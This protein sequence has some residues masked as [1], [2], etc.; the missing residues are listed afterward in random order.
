MFTILLRMLA[1][2]RRTTRTR[3]LPEDGLWRFVVRRA[4]KQISRSAEGET[5][6]RDI[7]GS[8]I[9]LCLNEQR[10]HRAQRCGEGASSRG[11]DC[12][13]HGAESLSVS[14]ANLCVARFGRIQEPIS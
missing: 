13:P 9:C 2:T 1:E 12:E 8:G 10:L 5:D 7:T 3:R 4:Q 11:S 6:T 14:S